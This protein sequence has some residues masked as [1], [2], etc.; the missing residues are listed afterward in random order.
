MGGRAGTAGLY[1]PC[2]GGARRRG[3]WQ[4]SVLSQ[5]ARQTVGR[6]ATQLPA[7]SQKLV[8]NSETLSSTLE[9]PVAQTV[10]VP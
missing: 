5:D 7:P 3:Y 10:E 4:P 2:A 6:P 9:Q 1:G 8:V